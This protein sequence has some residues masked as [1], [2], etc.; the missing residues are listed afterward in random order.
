MNQSLRINELSA[1]LKAEGRIR[2][3]QFLVTDFA[4]ALQQSMANSTPWELAYYDQLDD[5]PKKLLPE[6]YQQKKLDWNE[7]LT[8]RV[9]PKDAQYGFIYE[10]YMIVTAYL[11]GRDKGHPLHGFLEFLNHPST[12]N[13]FRKMTGSDAIVK[14]D[15]QA[16]HYRGGHFL[17]QHNDSDSGKGRLFAY[18]LNLCPQW[19]ADF[20]GL[21]HFVKH[22]E[23]VDTY[24]PSFNTLNIFSVPQEHFVSPVAT[25][26]TEG[27]YSITGWMYSK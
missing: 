13:L 2:V 18:V 12:L 7:F 27:R 23:V 16:T 25:F 26:C 21:L 14:I 10:S 6:E 24:V 19:S 15:A 5:R 4:I 1:L 11:E 22:N 17:R 9:Y 8:S 3:P 20:G